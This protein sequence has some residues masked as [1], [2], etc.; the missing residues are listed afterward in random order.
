M[1]TDL[2]YRI[3]FHIRLFLTLLLLFG[4]FLLSFLLFQFRRERLYKAERVNT[5]LQIINTRLSHYLADHTA[6]DSIVME[7]RRSVTENLRVTVLDKTGTVLY[8]TDKS[9]PLDSFA[10]HANRPEIIRA[11]KNGSGYT[12]RRLSETTNKEYFYAATLTG[13]YVVRSAIP[14]SVSLKEVLKTDKLFLP[15]MIGISII[16]SCLALIFTRRLGNNIKRLKKFARLADNGEPLHDIGPFPKDELGDISNHIIQLYSRLKQ[17]KEALESEHKVVEQQKQEQTRI[18]KQLTQNINHELKTPV[19]IIQ[20]YLETLMNNPALPPSKK[21]AFIES[22]YKQSDRLAQ[23]LNDISTITRMDEASDI[24]EKTELNLSDIIKDVFLDLDT[25]LQEKNIKTVLDFPDKIIV[26]GNHGLLQSIFRNLTDNAITYS[27]CD[28][29]TVRL[30]ES[31]PDHYAFI[32]AD[33]G[34]GIDREHL[35]RIFERFYR[36]DKGRSRRM[37]GT[38]LGLSIVK[39]ALLLHG[40]SIHARKREEGGVEFIFTIKKT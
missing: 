18:K 40:G 33:N 32:Y 24:I 35:S 38:G 30:R 10:N 16:I 37:G 2:R 13:D 21:Q 26:Q 15:V 29:I 8:D 39:N 5:E 22:C 17:T 4:L 25:H 19:S 31:G 3:S 34:I 12:I 23:L 20:G 28:T 27:G 7:N 6:M 11:M 9:L 36:V 1:G 14:Y